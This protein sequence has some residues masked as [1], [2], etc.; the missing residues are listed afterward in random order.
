MLF[1]GILILHVIFN[2]KI[3]CT[4]GVEDMPPYFTEKGT[5]T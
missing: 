3:T 2:G 1:G 5:I 4:E